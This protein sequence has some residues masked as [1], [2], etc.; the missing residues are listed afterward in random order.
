MFNSVIMSEELKLNHPWT[1]YWKEP[2]SSYTN[3]STYYSE[4]LRFYG[5]ITDIAKNI[6][7]L[8]ENQVQLTTLILG[9]PMES[10]LHKKDCSDIYLFQWQQLFPKHIFNFIKYY[11]KLNNDININIIIVSPDDI[12][13]DDK[14][15]EPLFTIKC[16]DYKFV[17][18]K[19]REYIHNSEKLTIKVDIFTCPFPQLEKRKN[20]I[21][22]CNLVV[23]KYIPDYEIKDFAPTEN[24]IKFIDIFY[25]QFEKIASNSRSN[26]IINSFA[27]FRNIYD[28][29]TFGL[30]PTLL[31][32]ANKYQ[33]I[34][35]EWIFDECN[36]LTRI[37]SKIKMTIDHFNNFV[38]YVEPC[39]VSSMH[40][41]KKINTNILKNKSKNICII[42][43]FPYYNLVYRQID[44]Y[45]QT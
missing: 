38:S 27:V 13:M 37:V 20:I 3:Y 2:M 34:A 32:I 31:E 35:T 16:D 42:I 11:S 36:F 18:I 43:K 1:I 33:I 14:Y 25:Y 8:E 21:E 6:E 4:L 44:K 45:T 22:K 9:T 7:I 19:N 23:C 40:D 5:F 29:G 39:Y 17:K 24:D 28:F 26:L 10:A 41:Y 12:F 30:F 15:H